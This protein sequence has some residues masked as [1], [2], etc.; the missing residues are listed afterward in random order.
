MNVSTMKCLPV[1]VLF[2][3]LS[4][5]TLWSDSTF[6]QWQTA[7]NEHRCQLFH[8]I[9]SSEKLVQSR[10][11]FHD[12]GKIEGAANTKATEHRVIGIATVPLGI[13][14][15][16]GIEVKIDD[17]PLLAELVDCTTEQGCRAA[18]NVDAATLDAL[19]RG[20]Q[21]ALTVQDRRNDRY[22]TFSY[23]LDGFGE[24]YD[25]FLRRL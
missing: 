15:P 24:A 9:L 10:V 6:A 14:L 20:K 3:S 1:V 4:A 18:F 2:A 25:E 17:K 8:E 12:V 23:Q 13:Y 21:L 5:L 16:A 19:K 22:V 7:C 11:Y